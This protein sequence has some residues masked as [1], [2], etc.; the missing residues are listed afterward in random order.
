M[1]VKL[2]L[3][4]TGKKNRISYRIVD[5]ITRSKRDS[6]FLEILGYFLPH[7]NKA[8]TLDIK[9]DRVAYWVSKGAKPTEA[10]GKLLEKDKNAGSNRKSS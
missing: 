9:A 7:E 2:R 4:R 5:Q 1:S 8:T 10:V 3:A 6:K